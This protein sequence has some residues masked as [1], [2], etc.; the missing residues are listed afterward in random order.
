MISGA[1]GIFDKIKHRINNRNN[2]IEIGGSVHGN[3]N[4]NTTIIENPAVA[5]NRIKDNPEE[6]QV[7]M[8]SISQVVMN[9]SKALPEGYQPVIQIKDGKAIIHS[10]PINEE[11]KKKYPQHI[12]GKMKISLPKGMSFSEALHRA[13][14][15]QQPIDVEMTDLKM[16]LGKVV[17]PF[18]DE[19][20][21]KWRNSIYK[22][23]PEELPPAQKYI[24][25]IKGS[26]YRYE[27]MLR[28]QPV[29]P[30]DKM[31][32]LSNG[33]E[34]DFKLIIKHNFATHTT[35]VAYRFKASNWASVCQYLRF[36]KAADKGSTLYINLVDHGMDVFKTEL[37]APLY[38]DAYEDIDYNLRIAEDIVLIENQYNINYST[39]IELTDGDI[40]LIYF[41]AN[42]IKGKAEGFTWDRFTVTANIHPIS[43]EALKEEFTF[44]YNEI[45]D[46]TIL[47]TKICGLKVCYKMDSAFIENSDEI[48]NLMQGNTAAEQ[49]EIIMIPGTHGNHGE[50]IVEM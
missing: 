29:D 45:E 8:N 6:L 27:L 7:T 44:Q 26:P 24:I 15:S 48:I 28:V 46:I 16:K 35:N 43:A 40:A 37:Q 47:G 10:E 2:S 13:K 31:F 34:T 41:L 23:V 36:M 11:A 32:I 22:I 38:Q 3:I 30:D 19:F 1:M 4:Q 12:E 18:Q 39:E 42:S 33:E 5:V 25:G 21:K 9:G 17:D 50:R 14:I 49:V 20:Q